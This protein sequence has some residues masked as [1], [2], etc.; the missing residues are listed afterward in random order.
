M[1]SPSLDLVLSNSDLDHFFALS[2]DEISSSLST[3]PSF[4]VFP[5][6][7]S[8][9]ISFLELIL[10]SLALSE[11]MEDSAV[12]SSILCAVLDSNSCVSICDFFLSSLSESID[13]LICAF[14]PSLFS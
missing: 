13:S 12:K 10:L 2:I 14:I 6:F 4:S 8:G 11:S 3:L 5:G 9:S 1:F 7:L